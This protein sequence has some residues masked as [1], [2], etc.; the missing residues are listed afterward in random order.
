MPI[1][2]SEESYQVWCNNEC[3]PEQQLYSVVYNVQ[4]G[5][6]GWSGQSK[7]EI[8]IGGILAETCSLTPNECNFML[9]D[10]IINLHN[11]L[12]CVCSD[13]W[14]GYLHEE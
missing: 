2:R 11:H 7:K 14:H 8:K 4:D 3:Y 5:F 9:I 6:L 1:P 10:W 12:I 13:V